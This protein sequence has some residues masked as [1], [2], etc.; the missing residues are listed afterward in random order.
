[1]SDRPPTIQSVEVSDVKS[2]LDGLLD[3]VSRKE[4]RVLVE[5]GGAPVAAIVSAEDL[6]RLRRLDDQLARDFAVL[7]ELQAAFAGVPAEE[8]E[9]ETAKALAEVRAEMRAERERGRATV[10]AK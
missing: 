9:R 10:P 6:E 7:E 1:M 8:I 4:A 5:D 2:R 3:R